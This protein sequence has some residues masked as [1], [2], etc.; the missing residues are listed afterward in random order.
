MPIG[1]ICNRDV[2]ISHREDT[3]AD[4]AKLMREHHV[5]D[6]VVVDE[7]D[8][9]RFLSGLLQTVTW[10]WRSWRPSSTK[11]SLRLAISC[12]RNW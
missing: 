4:A 3:V 7:R 12:L 9:V 5:G 2:I 11:R 10:W 8:G 1:E 6:V